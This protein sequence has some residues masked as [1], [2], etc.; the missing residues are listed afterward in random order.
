MTKNYY[1]GKCTSFKDAGKETDGLTHHKTSTIT[2]NHLQKNWYRQRHTHYTFHD[3]TGRYEV[4][5]KYCH[6]Q[7]KKAKTY[8]DLP[9]IHI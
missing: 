8:N 6:R 4:A 3:F 1:D 2:Q 5:H 9:Q 7:K